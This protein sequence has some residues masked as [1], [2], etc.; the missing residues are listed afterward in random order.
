MSGQKD[1]YGIC[2]GLWKRYGW[3]KWKWIDLVERK[4]LNKQVCTKLHA[5]SIDFVQHKIESELFL[6]GQSEKNS[7]TFQ[8]PKIFKYKSENKQPDS[9]A[10]DSL[11]GRWLAVR[12]E[13]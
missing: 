1:L 10:S 6:P 4:A 11:K 5:C 2:Y 9:M 13:S 8:I 3:R 7:H 12:F